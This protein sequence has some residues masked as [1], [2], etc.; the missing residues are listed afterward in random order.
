MQSNICINIEILFH[1]KLKCIIT[2]MFL[3]CLF[4]FGQELDFRNTLEESA[5]IERQYKQYF[6]LI[7]VNDNM[8]AAY[9]KLR[10]A[11][12][13]LSTEAQWVPV[14]WVYWNPNSRTVMAIWSTFRSLR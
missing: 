6:D 5:K 1:L 14:T 11:I 13:A 3:F 2:I 4:H 10:R 12:E 8:D 7:I 9:D